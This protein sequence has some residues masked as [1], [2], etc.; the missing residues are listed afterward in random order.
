MTRVA[1]QDSDQVP[2]LGNMM[3]PY[4]H[5][6]A[7]LLQPDVSNRAHERSACNPQQRK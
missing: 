5:R 1:A 6:A 4:G 7:H 3:C 2:R